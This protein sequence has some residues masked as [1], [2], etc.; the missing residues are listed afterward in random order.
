M[1]LNKFSSG[2]STLFAIPDIM[3]FITSII[4]LPIEVKMLRKEDPSE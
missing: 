3:A 2:L 4:P 1:L